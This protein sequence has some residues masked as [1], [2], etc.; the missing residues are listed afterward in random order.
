M[1]VTTVWC[2]PIEIAR[3][4]N[5]IHIRTLENFAGVMYFATPTADE[6]LTTQVLT[7]ASSALAAGDMLLISYDPADLAGSAF[8][9]QEHDCRRILGI[10]LAA[11][12]RPYL[13]QLDDV[14]GEQRRALV[15]PAR[16]ASSSEP[17]P[18]VLYFHGH[19]GDVYDSAALCR[20]H[21]LWPEAVV[22]YA[23][24]TP[25]TAHGFPSTQPE[26]G[27]QLRF[28]YK[29]AL[30]QTKD[31]TY[32]HQLLHQLRQRHITDSSRIYAVGHSS[33]GFFTF[34]LTQLMPHAFARF[35][36]VGAYSR[37]K[38]ELVDAGSALANQAGPLPLV[39]SDHAALPRPIL[40]LFGKNDTVF[41]QDSPTPEPGWHATQMSRS[42]RT[43]VELAKRNA[44]TIPTGSFWA[45]SVQLSPPS[46]WQHLGAPVTWQLYD[47]DHSWPPT[48]SDLVVQ[49]FRDG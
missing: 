41:D 37:F 15:Y 36:V 49:F 28:P 27:W 25:V 38:V 17:A 35:A 31:L 42:R 32:V 46:Q 29:Y 2:T 11:A 3:F 33:G 20:F 16:R 40:Y 43:L 34:S 6:P 23:E 18:V 30:G 19:G 44:C 48:A 21:S 39:Q 7:I 47:G 1:T 10:R 22:A 26:R 14:E 5:R 4:A 45:A 8:G 12:R 24:G 13:L 9:C